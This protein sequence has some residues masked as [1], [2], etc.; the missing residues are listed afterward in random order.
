MCLPATLSATAGAAGRLCRMLLDFVGKK[1]GLGVDDVRRMAADGGRSM[2]DRSNR[3]MADD[4][5]DRILDDRGKSNEVS[6]LLGDQ[7]A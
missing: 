4:R 7:I 2:A 1:Q 6:C 5:S 3:S